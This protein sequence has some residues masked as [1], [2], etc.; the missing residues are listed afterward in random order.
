MVVSKELEKLS[1]IL[2]FSPEQKSALQKLIKKYFPE[3]KIKFYKDLSG[4]WRISKI[5]I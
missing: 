5:K 3:A 4:K 1:V 2:E